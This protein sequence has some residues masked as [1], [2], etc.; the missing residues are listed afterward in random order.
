M[1][2]LRRI[3]SGISAGLLVSIGGCVFLALANNVETKFVGA[4]LFAVALLVICYRGYSLFTG[5]VGFMVDNHSKDAWSVLLLGLFGNAIGTLAMGLAVK[6]ALPALAETA[7]VACEA[8]LEQEIGQTI[9]RGM[10]CGVLM[11]LAVCIYRNKNTISGIVFCIPVFILSGFEHS[12]ADMFYFAASG[13]VNAKVFLF[14]AVVIVSNGL[15]AI[16]MSLLERF[17]KEEVKDAK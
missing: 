12:V 16:M 3:I 9:I 6:Y 17:G 8:R 7:K 10:L 5:K 4:V 13:I 2:M 1:Y 11:Y 14:I 15:G